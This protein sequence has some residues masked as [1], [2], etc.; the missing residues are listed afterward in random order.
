[1]YARWLDSAQPDRLRRVA[2]LLG[3]AVLAALLALFVCAPR[4]QAGGGPV[5]Q[6]STGWLHTCILR[7][8]GSIVCLGDNA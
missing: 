5:T 7:S 2:G 3:L 4:A 8:D 6:V 1:M